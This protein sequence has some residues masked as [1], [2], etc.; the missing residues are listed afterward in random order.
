MK[1][2]TIFLLGFSICAFGCADPYAADKPVEKKR[3]SIIGKKTQ[4]IGEFKA[5]NKDFTVKGDE[6]PEMNPINPL[7]SM[8][9]YGPTLQKL[10]K[11]HIQQAL[12]LFQAEHDRYPK[13]H[14]EFMTKIIKQNQIEL[15]VLPGKSVYQYDV[16]NHELVIVTPTEKKDKENN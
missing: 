12:N 5:D 13:D 7:A 4:D 14:E 10:S 3:E 9:A 2:L 16:E 1:I 11:M 6:M 15:P 8:K